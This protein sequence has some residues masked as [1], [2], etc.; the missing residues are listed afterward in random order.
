[1]ASLQDRIGPKVK[2]LHRNLTWKNP[3]AD[4]QSP[5][6][7]T[8]EGSQSDENKY[9]NDDTAFSNDHHDVS[10]SQTFFPSRDKYTT[11]RRGFSRP[12]KTNR[13]P[14]LLK[15]M[16]ISR[17]LSEDGMS[18]GEEAANIERSLLPQIGTTQ[19]RPHHIGS[20]GKKDDQHVSD[21]NGYHDIA[22]S[23]HVQRRSSSPQTSLLS[24]PVMIILSFFFSVLIVYSSYPI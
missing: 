4:L 5:P 23:S 18:D 10:S 3:G 9:D 16:G 19:D 12:R 22:N 7:N 24:S 6:K 11:H 20:T 8:V 15:R 2:K 17:G 21:S 14:S 1:M 13:T